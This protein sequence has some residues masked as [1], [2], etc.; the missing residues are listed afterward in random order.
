ML[1]DNTA[2]VRPVSRI[3]YYEIVFR[4]KFNK[5]N[6]KKGFHSKPNKDKRTKII[7]LCRLLLCKAKSENKLSNVRFLTGTLV[8][9]NTNINRVVSNFFKNISRYV[10]SYVYVIEKHKSGSYHFH[11]IVLFN[12]KPNYD[13]IYQVYNYISS[14]Y[15]SQYKINKNNQLHYGYIRCD[16]L[17]F[18]DNNKKISLSNTSYNIKSLQYY[19]VKYIT[20]MV[21]DNNEFL[22]FRFYSNSYDLLN[23]SKYEFSITLPITYCS[24][25]YIS[26]NDFV[27]IMN[28]LEKYYHLIS[29]DVIKIYVSSA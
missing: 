16:K 11:A 24:Q 2:H 20:K 5:Q 25:N 8:G 22:N 9:T 23:L 27:F 3:C 28:D 10:T 14:K 4:K 21:E 17:Y 19:L 18:K 12:E 7:Q 6:L 13:K 1:I 29:D 26:I 15:H